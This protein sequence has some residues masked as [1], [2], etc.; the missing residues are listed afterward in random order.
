MYHLKCKP[1]V[2]RQAGPTDV[3]GSRE[4]SSLRPGLLT[5]LLWPVYSAADPTLVAAA[6]VGVPFTYLSYQSNH[7]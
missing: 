2:Q 1:S 3:R 5:T 6:A 7:L 4:A